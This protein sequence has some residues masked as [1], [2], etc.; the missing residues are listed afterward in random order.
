MAVRSYT[1]LFR[2]NPRWLKALKGGRAPT[3]RT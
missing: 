3:Q 1:G 2:F